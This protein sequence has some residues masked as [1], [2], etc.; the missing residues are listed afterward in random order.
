MS[1]SVEKKSET[2]SPSKTPSVR[3]KVN[4]KPVLADTQGLNI[5]PSKVKN[6]VSNFIVNKVTFTAL[7]ELRNALPRKVSK[8]VDGKVV[9][10]EVKETPY[11][12]L[13][14]E[15]RAYV[16][17][18]RD[19]YENCLKEEFAKKK[20]SSMQ[21]PIK[22]KYLEQKRVFKES[23]KDSSEASKE[24]DLES[25]NTKFDPK[26][27][28]EYQIEKNKRLATSQNNIKDA[29]SLVSK[30]NV[31]FSINA[32]VY[33][34]A[35]VELL[36][37]ELVRSSIITCVRKKKRILQLSHLTESCDELKNSHLYPLLKTFKSFEEMCKYS[38]AKSEEKSES[39]SAEETIGSFMTGDIPKKEQVK[40]GYCVGETCRQVRLELSKEEN[41][42]GCDDMSVFNHISVSKMFK[43]SCSVL[44]SE[45]VYRISK[46]LESE[47]KAR[48]VKT[49]T[50]NIVKNVISQYHL[51][52]GVDET[53]SSSFI[54]EVIKKFTSHSKKS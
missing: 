15:T 17:K 16:S 13:S 36:M 7:S 10:E 53:L 19:V 49:I 33:I 35:F 44:L 5:S 47:T 51:S 32:R 4:N 8:T 37:K 12:N 6:I 40:F 23:C 50:D 1:K 39:P 11:A 26:F 34:T 18:A 20:V 14:A 41:I 21:E 31:R 29:I 2:P 24:F 28:A 38:L 45:F 42:D 54:E 30:L 46:M 25:F 9:E 48:C 43:D 3:R 22:K 27:Y 52:H